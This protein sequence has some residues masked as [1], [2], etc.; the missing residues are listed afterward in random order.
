MKAMAVTVHLVDKHQFEIPINDEVAK[1][2]A[3][4]LEG[5]STFDILEIRIGQTYSATTPAIGWSDDE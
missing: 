1:S 2:L 3:E 4:A 5:M